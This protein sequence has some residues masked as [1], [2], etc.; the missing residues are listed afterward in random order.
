MGPTPPRAPR[1]QKGAAR[2]ESWWSARREE[3]LAIAKEGTPAY[4][5]DLASLDRAAQEI[6]GLGAIDR[7]LYAVK[8]NPHPSLLERFAAL[9]LGF[10]CVSP[11]EIAR[12]FEACPDVSPSR[13]LFTPNFAPRREY[14]AALELGVALTLDS[15]HPLEHWASSLAGREVFVRLDL[16]H[17]AGHHAHVRTAG[18]RS[19]F[20]IAREEWLDLAEISARVGV[21]IAG[22]H[23]HSGSGI[24]D[25][26]IWRRTALDLAAAA[27][28][29]P[30]ARVLDLGGGLGVA[31][32][33]RRRPLDLARL[34][35]A[36]AEVRSE[37]PRFEL[38]LEPGRFLVAEAG[39]L[40]A[41]VTQ[42]KG[43]HAA[44]EAAET[45]HYIGVDAGMNSLIRPMFYGAHHEIVNL[46]RWGDPT[47]VVADVVGPICESG[48]VLGVH[49]A[50]PAT[51]EG[52]VLA[53]AQTGAYGRV[54][55][56]WYNLRE[57]A[58]E[59]ILD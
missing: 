17:G 41:T 49:R 21:R 55:S 57:P 40:L 15:L 33:P 34:A 35:A 52:D 8:A 13:V 11:G 47:T 20:G 19:K 7:L 31:D 14:E 46:S 28:L 1:R 42:V 59:V 9:G 36:L 51:H 37:F 18:A 16:G 27:D 50:L 32:R 26:E 54:M 43:K 48:D 4:V 6:F 53:I 2:R 29:F 5:Y 30:D 44:T 56:S 12:V 10:E 24:L 25:P 38:W 22:L 23:S 39:V 45:V 58:R 3:L